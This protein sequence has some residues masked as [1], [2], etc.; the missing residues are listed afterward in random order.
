MIPAKHR[1]LNAAV[2]EAQIK[3]FESVDILRNGIGKVLITEGADYTNPDIDD[4]EAVRLMNIISK[5]IR[6][7]GIVA[8]NLGLLVEIVPDEMEGE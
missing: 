4:Y 2:D 7:L 5:A 8:D 3:I 1:I 6:K